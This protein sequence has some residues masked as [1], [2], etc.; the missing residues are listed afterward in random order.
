MSLRKLGLTAAVLVSSLGAFWTTPASANCQVC[1]Y[2]LEGNKRCFEICLYSRDWWWMPPDAKLQSP[3]DI[4]PIVRDL[5]SFLRNPTSAPEGDSGSWILLSPASKRA[6]I[7]DLKS[8]TL[9]E[10]VSGAQIP[11]K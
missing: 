1:I 8:A 7:V 5:Q 11:A 10:V 4:G 2:D 6:F 9:T 3:V